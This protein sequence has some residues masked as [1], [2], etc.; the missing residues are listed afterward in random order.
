MK[1]C[2]SKYSFRHWVQEMWYDHVDELNA[3]YN[4]TP[5]Y[6]SKDYF[7]KYKFWLKR[8]FQYR[9]KQNKESE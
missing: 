2:K 8:E 6:S 1:T 5:H 9:Q 3:Y 7:N 4:Q